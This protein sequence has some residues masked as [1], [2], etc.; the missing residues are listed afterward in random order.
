MEVQGAFWTTIVIKTPF[1]RKKQTW[2]NEHVFTIV[3]Q[4]LP[5]LSRRGWVPESWA[6]L[7]CWLLKQG[8][9]WG[10]TSM[11]F[12]SALQSMPHANIWK[13]AKTR[14]V[15]YHLLSPS[16]ERLKFYCCGSQLALI[17]HSS[18]NEMEGWAVFQSGPIPLMWKQKQLSAVR[19]EVSACSVWRRSGFLEVWVASVSSPEFGFQ[20][21]TFIVRIPHRIHC[22]EKSSIF[23]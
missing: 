17:T 3:L 11:H 19:G 16:V 23:I 10:L 9:C 2:N 20:A 14:R 4:A 1:G 15:H 7:L 21:Q 22:E 12:P 6:L 8:E 18:E 13:K 5:E